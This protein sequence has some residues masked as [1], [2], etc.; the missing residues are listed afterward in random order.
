MISH[1][2][3]PAFPGKIIRGVLLY[4]L[5]HAQFIKLIC[6][7]TFT[8]CVSDSLYSYLRKLRPQDSLRSIVKEERNIIMSKK[9]LKPIGGAPPNWVDD[10]DASAGAY[11][12]AN[13]GSV[14]IFQPAA[15]VNYV[16]HVGLVL[17]GLIIDKVSSLSLKIRMISFFENGVCPKTNSPRGQKHI[18]IPPSIINGA[19]IQIHFFFILSVHLWKFLLGR[20]FEYPLRKNNRVYP[21]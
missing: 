3:S 1:N 5:Q 18:A 2:C 13:G 21:C 10:T 4:F 11:Y 9:T 19:M 6:F 8:L 20:R 15:T 17:Y 16:S 12:Y 14:S 7:L